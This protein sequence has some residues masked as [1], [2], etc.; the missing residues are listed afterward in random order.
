[1]PQSKLVL[2]TGATGKQGGAVVEALLTRGHQV[3]ALLRKSP[4]AGLVRRAESPRHYGR[5]LASVLIGAARP[6]RRFAFVGRQ[7]HLIAEPFQTLDQIAPQ[8][9]GFQS[10]KVVGSQVLILPVVLQHVIQN[11]Q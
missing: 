3:R 2:V 11:H 1:M 4:R 5:W 8:T 7:A 9:L 6:L 10:V